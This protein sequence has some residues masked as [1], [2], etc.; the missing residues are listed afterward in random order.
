M[1]DVNGWLFLAMTI[2]DMYALLCLGY[3]VNRLLQA[4][5]NRRAIRRAH[6]GLR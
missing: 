1:H 6:P 3:V 2:G 4:W 5:R